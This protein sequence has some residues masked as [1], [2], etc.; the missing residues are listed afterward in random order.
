MIDETLRSAGVV[1]NLI[2]S[3]WYWLNCYYFRNQYMIWIVNLIGGFV[4]THS[5][6]PIVISSFRFHYDHPP[7]RHTSSRQ[8]SVTRMALTPQNKKPLTLISVSGTDDDDDET[9]SFVRDLCQKCF[10]NCDQFGNIK[11]P[12]HTQ[13]WFTTDAICIPTGHHQSPWPQMIRLP[14]RNGLPS[15]QFLSFFSPSLSLLSN[16]IKDTP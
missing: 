8:S 16:S 6:V 13:H 7:H 12:M 14:F 5:L 15:L 3:N 10:S 4:Y 2:G 11:R 1:L 9:S